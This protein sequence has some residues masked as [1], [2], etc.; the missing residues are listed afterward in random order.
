MRRFVV[1][2]VLAL[3]VGLSG[4][5]AGADVADPDAVQVAAVDTTRLPDVE[6]SIL[7]PPSA[8]GQPIEPN[9]FALA[10]GGV[11]REIEVRQQPGSEQDIVLAIDVSGGMSGP[12]L[13]DVK[14]AASDF[15]RQAP[16][17]AH[18]GIVAIS[19]T[20]QV[21]SELSS[22][23]DD[24]LRRIDG[25][26]AGGNSAIA[27]S[28]VAA[29]DVL[30]RGDAPNNILLLLTDGADTSSSRAM[31]EIPSVLSRSHVSLYTVQMSTPETN[32][33]LLEQI[34]R[35]SRGQYATAEDTAA[36]G[37]IYQS[38]ARALGNLYVVRYRS[39]SGGETQ[40]VVSVRSGATHRVS[41]P[42]PV[43]LP[44]ADRMSQPDVMAANGFWTS[45]TGLGLGLVA[46][47]LALCA[48]VVAVVGKAAPGISAERRGRGAGDDSLLHRVS[49]RLVQWIDQNLR[50]RGR[51]AARTQ[52]LQ[53]AGL[54]MR[55]GDF[56]TLVAAA[57]VTAAA[58]GV[59]LSGTLLALLLVVVVVGLSKVILGVLAG[60]RR[61]AFA[62][63]LDDSVQLLASNLR[64][65][66]SL[67]RAL[68]AVSRE[69]EA[70]T[71][72][73]FARVVNETRVGRDLGDSLEDL[74]QRMQCEDFE[75]IAQ[76]ISI[77]REVGGDLAEVLD[78]VGNTIRERNQIRRQVKALA[79]EGKLSAYVLMA[80]P[81]GITGFL[82]MNNPTYL[83]RFTEGIIGY[84]MIAACLVLLTVGA[85]WLRK[86]VNL[87]F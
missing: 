56:I 3:G 8:T 63:Q 28:V 80:L 24:L 58:I 30:D 21:I 44:G 51:I 15:V 66:H 43:T 17:G 73:E 75:W 49:E 79:A 82:Y 29:A 14:R 33:A 10:E 50:R 42:F 27:D 78:Q 72:E 52:A 36:L 25:L 61:A 2:V 45:G 85:L 32:S 35:E 6:V 69:A 16:T 53:E 23:T 47:Y 9:T 18:I 71:A 26:K 57:A 4:A 76:A 40:V 62:D 39:E 20:P 7:A 5:P 55:P 81:F 65:G 11:P 70:P 59:L 12:A 67:L 41:D 38:A 77:H 86:L 1:A 48:L 64:A 13:D 19:S 34:A 31:S 84:S 60:R 22:D 83:E 54:K 46:T 87:K 68:D 74:A 37:A